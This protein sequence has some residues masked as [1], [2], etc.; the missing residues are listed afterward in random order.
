MSQL[1]GLMIESKVLSHLSK[2]SYEERISAIETAI[3]CNSELFEGVGSLVA[4][5]PGK[6]V[7]LN[8][9]GEFYSA[10]YNMYEDNA[11]RFSNAEKMDV[12]LQTTKGLQESAI[13]DFFEGGSLV[14]SMVSL[15]G[16]PRNEEQAPIQI[17][18]NELETLF[19][20]GGV[21]R[22]YV[23]E[24]REKFSR[25]AFDPKYGSPMIDVEPK[26]QDIY[27]GS[28]EAMEERR[29]EVLTALNKLEGRLS[30]LFTVT[31]E[32]FTKFKK[33]TDGNRDQEADQLLSQY[34]SFSDD[35]LEHLG[36]VG[37]YVSESI[38]KGK[39]GCVACSA[40]VYDHVV[41]KATELELGG[42]LIQKVSTELGNSR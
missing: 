19:D 7:V 10:Q 2:G 30:R 33:A 6:V 9:F 38:G 39:S 24:N 21:W 40:L 1:A 18:Q 22:M 15:L 4:T 8:E 37:G 5:Y 34:E 29:G 16:V 25:L 17:V 35:Y 41:Q 20:G 26:F 31:S 32:S 12:P 13:E 14:T 42:R 11:V 27:E 36:R 28:E 3:E 23:A